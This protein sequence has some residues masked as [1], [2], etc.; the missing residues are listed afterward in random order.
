MPVRLGNCGPRCG[1]TTLLAGR[2][3][4][5]SVEGVT[6]S[7]VAPAVLRGMAASEGVGL[8]CGGVAVALFSQSL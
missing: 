2:L 8:G 6:G 1:G 3:S 5:L 4:A 7:Q